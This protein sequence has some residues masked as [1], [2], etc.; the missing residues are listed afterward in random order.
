MD[1]DIYLRTRYYKSMLDTDNLLKGEHYSNLPEC[2]I[3]FI[4]NYDPIG[5]NLPSY[6]YKTCCIE[7][8]SR[9]MKDKITKKFYIG[10]QYTFSKSNQVRFS[11]GDERFL[12]GSE[13][14][15]GS[16]QKIADG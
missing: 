8:P 4:C 9:V 1:V 14:Q 11:I 13:I 15:V 7:N 2:F 5:D 3:I 12:F 6:T 10:P 16:H